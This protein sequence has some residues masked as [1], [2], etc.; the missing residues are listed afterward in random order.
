MTT[1]QWIYLISFSL[2][3]GLGACNKEGAHA[4]EHGEGEHAHEETVMLP[5]TKIRDLNFDIGSIQKHMLYVTISANGELAVPPQHSALVTAVVGANIQDV[6]VLE[7]QKVARGQTLAYIA[8]PELVKMQTDFLKQMQTLAFLETE[9][10][11]RKKMYA[12]K[13]VSGKALQEAETQY[14]QAL[15]EIKGLTQQLT[16]LHVDIPRLK[17]GEIAARLPVVSPIDGFVEK[18]YVRVGQYVGEQQPMFSVINNAHLHADL[19]VYESDADRVRIGQRVF[20]HTQANPDHHIPARIIAVSR[21]FEENPK[22]IHVHADID[23]GHHEQQGLI[24]GMFIEGRIV[25][26]SFEAYALPE[27]AVIVE[28]GQPF[29]F[30]AQKDGDNWVFTLFPLENATRQDSFYVLNRPPSDA[31]FVRNNAYYLIAELRKGETEHEH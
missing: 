9:Y 12:E 19:R 4:D 3:I 30:T 28:E 10:Q 15:A 16:Q 14:R 1:T 22:A 7:G 11:R 17:K 18:I 21:A 2:V 27:A 26:D 13:A 24:A 23:E 31:F 8:H 20:F 5:E 29:A 6:V 25:V